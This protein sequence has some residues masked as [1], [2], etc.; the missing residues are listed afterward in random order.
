MTI[1][2]CKDGVNKRSRTSQY[3]LNRCWL[4]AAQTVNEVRKNR[5]HISALQDHEIEPAVHR[6]VIITPQISSS[7]LVRLSHGLTLRIAFE[8][9]EMALRYSSIFGAIRSG[10]GR[11]CNR[12]RTDQSENTAF[13][14]AAIA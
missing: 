11:R 1:F 14:M 10:N 9:R 3:R 12:H 6:D 2:A 13:R 8:F 7:D 5:S 4:Q